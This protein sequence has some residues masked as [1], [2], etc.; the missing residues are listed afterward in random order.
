[1]WSVDLSEKVAPDETDA[2][3]L[4]CIK[5]TQSFITPSLS[6]ISL[7]PIRFELWPIFI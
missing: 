6:L 3:V 2:L 7:F 1:M 5:H 4:A